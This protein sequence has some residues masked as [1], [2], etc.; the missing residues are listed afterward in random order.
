MDPKDLNKRVF[1]A[2]IL[3]TLLI[4]S[5]FVAFLFTAG[6][7]LL[8]LLSF[9]A[10]GISALEFA[11]FSTK[12]GAG[13]IRAINYFLILL[14]PSFIFIV[15]LSG[16]NPLQSG[17]VLQYAANALMVGFSFSAIVALAYVV[18]EG[19]EELN[20]AATIS[21]EIFIGL[22]LIGFGGASL[23][24]ITMFTASY[25][26]VIW[27]FL[28]VCLNDI[29]AYFVGSKF[30]TL[31]I[32]EAI[33]PGKTVLGSFAGLLAG[34]ITA[35]LFFGLVGPLEHFY[36]IALI[37]IFST[38]AAQIGDLAKS[39][40]KRLHQV[41]DSGNILPGH[42][43]VVDRL[44]GVLMAAPARLVGLLVFGKG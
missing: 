20:K 25:Q 3:T 12:S 41:K 22:I 19:R 43:G 39:Y 2:I 29:A 4:G 44:D 18:L 15:R 31:K 36:M 10:I 1:T 26:Y 35:I 14:L 17:L 9:A 7:L 30:G 24:A 21:Q 38:L 27:L 37:G 40:L 5:C 33:S 13:S 6:K 42:G 32:A 23:L 16:M 28:V 8:L 11:S 34:S